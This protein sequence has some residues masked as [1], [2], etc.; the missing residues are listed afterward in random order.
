MQGEL[1]DQCPEPRLFVTGWK[2]STVSNNEAQAEAMDGHAAFHTNQGS[3]ECTSEINNGKLSI[4]KQDI[5]LF[6]MS[7]L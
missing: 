5:C 7:L 6:H 3:A 4:I 1:G 2:P